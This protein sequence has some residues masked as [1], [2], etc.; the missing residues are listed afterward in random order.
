ME[1]ASKPAPARSRR[2]GAAV[3]ELGELEIVVS[4]R[5]DDAGEQ[6]VR[7]LQRTRANVR[8]LWP[9]PD[10]FPSVCDV[11]VADLVAGL[12]DRLPWVPGESQATLIVVVPTVPPPDLDLLRHCAPDAVLHKP[13][14]PHAILA[15]LVIGRS[16]F[17]YER[18]L[19][20]R[21]DKLDE[22]LRSLRSVER[23]KAILIRTRQMTEEEAYHHLRRLA[24]DRRMS[25][26]AVAEAIVDTHDILG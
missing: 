8:P 2:Q 1:I 21:I 26:S 15:A 18:R 23:A 10:Q 4:T 20:S 14:T 17:L 5:R 24:M 12:P 19:R 6:I 16:Q 11:I 7:E 22:T 9:M 13:A 3:A 25:V